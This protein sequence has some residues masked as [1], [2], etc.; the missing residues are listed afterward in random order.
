MKLFTLAA[1]GLALAIA[2]PAAAQNVEKVGTPGGRILTAVPGMREW[3]AT[4]PA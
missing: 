1:A 3:A 2:G 4:V